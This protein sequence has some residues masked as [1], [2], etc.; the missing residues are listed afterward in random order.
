LLVKL[1]HSSL[2]PEYREARTVA[3]VQARR[4]SIDKA[5]KM[6]GFKATVSLEEGLAQLISW[7]QQQLKTLAMVGATR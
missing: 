1:N 6:L 3:N 2:P 7:K 5:E 4:A